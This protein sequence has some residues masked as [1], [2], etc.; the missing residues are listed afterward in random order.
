MMLRLWKHKMYLFLA[1]LSIF[2]HAPL[3]TQ[4]NWKYCCSVYIC[5]PTCPVALLQVDRAEDGERR[6]SGNLVEGREHK[7]RTSGRIKV[8][9][10][11]D[12]ISSFFVYH[13]PPSPPYFSIFSPFFS[14]PRK[15]FTSVANYPETQMEA[16]TLLGGLLNKHQMGKFPFK[17]DNDDVFFTENR[18]LGWK[19]QYLTDLIRGQMYPRSSFVRIQILCRE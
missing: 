7:K 14:S 1:G 10:M 2:R 5:G 15:L 16:P 19:P 13:P 17:Q 6:K 4:N 18:F 11:L 8:V 9:T 3:Q 12:E